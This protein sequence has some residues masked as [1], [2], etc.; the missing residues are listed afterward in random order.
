MTCGIRQPPHQFRRASQSPTAAKRRARQTLQ[1][2][3]AAPIRG[4]RPTGR[5]RH[6]GPHAQAHQASHRAEGKKRAAAKGRDEEGKRRSSLAAGRRVPPPE[7]VRPYRRPTL[8]ETPVAEMRQR[9]LRAT[10]EQKRRRGV[11]KY[12]SNAAADAAGM[13]E[14]RR[15]PVG[16][17]QSEV[18][19]RKGENGR[20]CR[21]RGYC[22]KPSATVGQGAGRELAAGPKESRAQH[23]RRSGAK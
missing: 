9:E 2:R 18:R 16:G 22:D 14:A 3:P 13:A 11:C 7:D 1:L 23:R 5:Q 19:N 12:G 20:I 15:I 17:H 4:I 10:L 8:A 6:F 21:R